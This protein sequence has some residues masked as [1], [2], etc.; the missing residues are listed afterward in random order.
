MDGGDGTPDYLGGEGTGTS[1]PWKWEG[2]MGICPW[3]DSGQNL[4]T[5]EV[6]VWQISRGGDAEMRGGGWGCLACSAAPRQPHSQMGPGK[7]G[8]MQDSKTG[9]RKW[10]FLKN[11]FSIS[12]NLSSHTSM[13]D[14]ALTSSMGTPGTNL[15]LT[16]NGISSVYRNYIPK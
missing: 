7:A 8:C 15:P 5:V 1:H 10:R 14:W 2:A 3:H 11:R 16:G 12:Y 9:C 6:E 4:V 13:L